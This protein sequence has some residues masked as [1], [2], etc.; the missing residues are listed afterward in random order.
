[1]S[2]IIASLL[3]SLGA[4]PW[5]TYITL[6]SL[7]FVAAIAIPIPAYVALAGAGSLAAGGYLNIFGVLASAL[8]GSVAGDIAGYLLASAYGKKALIS[9]GFRRMLTSPKYEAIEAHFNEYPQAI[10]VVT[11]LITEVGPIVNLVSGL[12][13]VSFKTFLVFDI[14]GE[15]SYVLLFGLAGYF[16]GD[17]WQDNTDFLYKGMAMLVLLGLLIGTIQVI[18]VKFRKRAHIS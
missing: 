8:T 2:S 11:R 4:H 5:Y 12:A 13:S 10:I 18:N 14:L 7:S 6:F 15:A 1:M 3:A 17:A 9:M 16:L